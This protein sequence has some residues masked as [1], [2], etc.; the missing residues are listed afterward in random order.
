MRARGR[1]GGGGRGRRS[2]RCKMTPW[3]VG[4][5]RGE[6]PPGRHKQGH[7]LPPRT[8]EGAEGEGHG[9]DPLPSPPLLGFLWTS[10]LPSPL[11]TPQV[12]P[13]PPRFPDGKQGH[14]CVC[15]CRCLQLGRPRLDS[16]PS[17]PP[18][19]LPAPQFKAVLGWEGVEV[20]LLLKVLFKTRTHTPRLL[21]LQGAARSQLSCSGVSDGPYS[22]G[23]R[24]SR[25][26]SQ[27]ELCPELPTSR[28][29][30]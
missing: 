25:L 5:G 4:E 28:R 20:E 16:G 22:P 8:A 17:P 6:R 15:C 1:G 24:T 27:T 9:H 11:R 2:S 3:P 7:P 29:K 30:G 18:T 19:P 13:F 14:A 26:R 23:N 21:S 10:P 12:Q